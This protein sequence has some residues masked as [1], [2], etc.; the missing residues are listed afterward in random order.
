MYP[1]GVNLRDRNKNKMPRERGPEHKHFGGADGLITETV[2]GVPK[3][4]WRCNFCKGTIGGKIFPNAKAR[5]HLSGDKSL[6]NGMIVTVCP[7]APDEIKEQFVGIIKH[8]EAQ[9]KLKLQKRKRAE[10]LRRSNSLSSPAK[11]TRLGFGKHNSMSD[12]DVDE[13]WGRAFFGLDIAWNKI[14]KSLFR[15]AIEATKNCKPT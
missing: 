4:Y 13:A 7:R 9:K 15:S 6:R 8:K 14:N 2:H 12:E 11:Q 1:R 5:I 10:E 3:Y